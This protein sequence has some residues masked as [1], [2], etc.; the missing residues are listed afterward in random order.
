ML[1]VHAGVLSAESEEVI[2][3]YV[4][5]NDPEGVLASWSGMDP[6]SGIMEYRV[7]IGTTPGQTHLINLFVYYCV[8]I[9]LYSAQSTTQRF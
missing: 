1:L 2:D 4:L 6:E 8:L 5:H 3:G 7:A 9:K